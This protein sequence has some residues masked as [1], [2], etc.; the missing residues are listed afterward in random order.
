MARGHWLVK[1]E[2]STYSWE[3]FVKE[4]GTRWDGVRNPAARSHLAA[5][6]RG[7]P[8]LFYH[9]GGD[10]AVVGVARVAREAYPD[11]ADA[12]WLAVDLE[13]VKPL[14]RPVTLAEIKA[15]KAFAGMPLVRQPRLSVQPVTRAQH[16]AILALARRGAG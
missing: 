1:S 10:K 2:P 6:E 7:D 9:S 4:G 11:P 14:P 5:M 12:R 8:V 3:R 16:D 15:E 13:P